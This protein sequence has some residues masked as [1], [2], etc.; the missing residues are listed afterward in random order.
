MKRKNVLV[1]T[2][3]VYSKEDKN[4]VLVGPFTAV[5]DAAAKNNYSVHTLQLPLDGFAHGY[6][7]GMWTREKTA[8]VPKMLGSLSSLKY[9][10]DFFLVGIFSTK[11]LLKHRK[12]SIVIAIDP[13]SCLPLIFLRLILPFKL[14]F[15]CVDFNTHRFSNTLLQKI[16]EA[17]DKLCSSRADQTWVVS[18]KLRKYK[19]MTYKSTSHYVPNSTVFNSALYKNAQKS[20]TVTKLVW[21]GSCITK[22]QQEDLFKVLSHISRIRPDIEIHLCPTDRHD[23][24]EEN[25]RKVQLAKCTVHTLENAAWRAFVADC[26]VGIA[27]YDTKYG[28]TDFIEPLKIWDFMGSGL[29][30]IISREV[31]LSPDIL[32]AGVAYRLAT[33]NV[34]QDEKSLSDF[35]VRK[36]IDEKKSLCVSLAKKFDMQKI[37]GSLLGRLV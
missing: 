35:L 32:A 3:I 6:K 30:F 15:Y 29:P 34:I 21:G 19:K 7:S 2:H 16:Y 8:H 27:V 28:S 33:G 14:V 20:Q 1:I 24:F 23:E 25:A 9:I 4:K 36:A 13:L 26:H 22:E 5:C 10:V 17:A 11:Y 37:A 31:S 12:N 18:E